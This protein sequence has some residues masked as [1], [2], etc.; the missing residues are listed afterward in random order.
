[1]SSF[2]GKCDLY[3]TMSMCAL[4][5]SKDNHNVLVSDDLEAFEVFK[6]ETD[7]VIYQPVKIELN[8]YN[9]EMECKRNKSFLSREEHIEEVPDKRCKSG[10]KIHKY[11]TYR[12]FGREMT[13]E[14]INKQGYWTKKEIHFDDILDLV[15]YF[16]YIIGVMAVDNENHK[17]YVE[18]SDHSYVD[19]K[20]NDLLQSGIKSETAKYY[21]QR[22]KEKYKE[23]VRRLNGEKN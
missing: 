19:E 23:L 4:H 5:P 17:R 15:P 10:K 18:I 7:G 1:M 20:E 22:L 12:Y 3:D 9:A 16:P 6:K 21:R 8:D 2:S 14:Q 11:Y 13:L